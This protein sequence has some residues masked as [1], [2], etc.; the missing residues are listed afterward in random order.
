MYRYSLPTI[1]DVTTS[2]PPVT[3]LYYV[4][5]TRRDPSALTDFGLFAVQLNDVGGVLQPDPASPVRLTLPQDIGIAGVDPNSARD[6]AFSST[7]RLALVAEGD[8]ANVLMTVRVDRDGERV[9]GL[10]DLVVVA[11]LYSVGVPDPTLSTSGPTGSPSVGFRAQL[12]STPRS[13]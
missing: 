12:W 2:G 8:T 9:T 6:G 1:L 13:S 11:D 3:V 4:G 7:G 10:S 5:I